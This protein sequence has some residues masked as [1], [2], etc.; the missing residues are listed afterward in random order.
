MLF[1]LNRQKIQNGLI[2]EVPTYMGSEEHEVCMIPLQLVFES[3]NSFKWNSLA[4]GRI[5]CQAHL[6]FLN[7]TFILFSFCI[8]DLSIGERKFEVTYLVSLF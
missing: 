1:A 7:P 5:V 8:D 4:F 3:K 2:P 6:Y